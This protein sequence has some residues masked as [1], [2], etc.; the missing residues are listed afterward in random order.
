[1]IWGFVLSMKNFKN[2]KKEFSRQFKEKKTLIYSGLVFGLIFMLLGFFEKYLFY[3]GVLFFL[4]SYLY[5][6]AK[7]VDECCMVRKINVKNLT[8]GDWLYEDVKLGKKIIKQ[9]W[10]GLSKKEIELI[11][12]KHKKVLIRQGIPFVPVFLISFLILIYVWLTGILL[13]IGFGFF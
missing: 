7:S 11:Q 2:F 13:K 9:N 6:Y 1:M 12:G 10:E 4:I 5:V 8:E 3:F